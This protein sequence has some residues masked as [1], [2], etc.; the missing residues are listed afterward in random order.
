MF[1]AT[2]SPIFRS[3]RLYTTASGV[4]YPICYRSVTFLHHHITDQQHIGYNILQAVVYSIML[5]MMGEIVGRNM[6]S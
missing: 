3:I 2:I 1:R 5:L 6:S 4:L